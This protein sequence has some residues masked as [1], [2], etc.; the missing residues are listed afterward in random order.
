VLFDKTHSTLVYYPKGRESSHYTIPNGVTTIEEYAFE[1]CTNLT[2]VTIPN[3]VTNVNY[4]AFHSCSGLTS[5][6]FPDTVTHI[7]DWSFY[8]CTNLADVTLSKNVKFIGISAFEG[9]KSLTD[10]TLPDSITSISYSVFYRCDNL[11]SITIPSSV[12]YVYYAAFEH[13]YNLRDVYFTGS[14]TQWNLMRKEN[15]NNCLTNATIHYDHIIPT[16]DINGDGEVALEDVIYSLKNMVGNKELTAEQLTSAD[17]SRDGKFTI[18]D[19][20]L[21]QRLILEM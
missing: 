6:T 11:K 1:A 12:T 17:L 20:I 16:G 9:C 18:V 13:C 15:K 7:G 19:V 10:I 3:G 2:T 14:K 4:S 8:Y 5:V 21:M